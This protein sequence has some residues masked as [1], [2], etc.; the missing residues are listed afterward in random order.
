MGAHPRM[1]DV[2][3]EGIEVATKRGELGDAAFDL[4]ALVCN[5]LQELVG[6]VIAACGENLCD[7][8]FDLDER[9]AELPEL[10]R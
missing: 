4:S 8:A 3:L 2:L 9:Q 5:Q 6:V 10:P 7:E 1:A